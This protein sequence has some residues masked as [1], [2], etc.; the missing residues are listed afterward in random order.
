MYAIPVSLSRL[1]LNVAVEVPFMCS[2]IEPDASN[3]D[4]V[5]V[6]SA[7]S[8]AVRSSAGVVSI[9]PPRPWIAQFWIFTCPVRLFATMACPLPTMMHGLLGVPFA[10]SV[11]APLSVRSAESA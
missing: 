2:R 9:A 10:S 7:P 1:S 6:T 5:I 3:V 8:P 4:P 11:S